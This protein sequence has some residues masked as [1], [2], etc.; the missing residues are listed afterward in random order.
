MMVLRLLPAFHAHRQLRR[1]RSGTH[2]AAGRAAGCSSSPA[3]TVAVATQRT[4]MRGWWGACGTTLQAGTFTWDPRR[5]LDRW[6]EGAYW[7]CAGS[8]RHV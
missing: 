6:W 1:P 4:E 3:L 2:T 8:E 5:W 7:L